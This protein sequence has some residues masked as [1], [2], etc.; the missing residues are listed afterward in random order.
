V[1]QNGLQFAVLVLFA[2]NFF[3]VAVEMKFRSLDVLLTLVVI[4]SFVM[5]HT[6]CGTLKTAL[7]ENQVTA[8]NRRRRGR[9]KI[10]S[11]SL[12]SPQRRPMNNLNTSELISQLNDLAYA[13]HV[14]HPISP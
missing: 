3:C 1:E 14:S 5:I 9:K 2:V 7:W 6:H 10:S 8:Q 4:Q 11:D 13:S 12:V